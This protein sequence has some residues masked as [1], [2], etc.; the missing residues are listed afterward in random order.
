MLEKSWCVL[1]VLRIFNRTIKIKLDPRDESI[2]YSRNSIVPK[3][4]SASRNFF[5]KIGAESARIIVPMTNR[6]TQLAVF[7]AYF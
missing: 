2:T 1:L 4:I 5:E 7:H 3:G 6:Q